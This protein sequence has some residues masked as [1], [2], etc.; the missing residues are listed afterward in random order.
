MFSR[1]PLQCPSFSSF[2]RFLLAGPCHRLEAASYCR[3]AI[4]DRVFVV[5][6]CTLRPHAASAPGR[7]LGNRTRS[8]AA[9]VA[10]LRRLKFKSVAPGFL[11]T[12]TSRGHPCLRYS[13][14]PNH[15]SPNAHPSRRRGESPAPPLFLFDSLRD[16]QNNDRI[17]HII[18]AGAA[19][20]P[21]GCWPDWC[22]T[23][24][25]A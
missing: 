16:H 2:D 3:Q 12:I 4:F 13:A 10:T 15:Y 18:P 21:A 8:W 22:R 23:S 11:F 6:S 5:D 9:T 14:P 20:A 17:L 1:L 24:K 25:V 19:A 7:R